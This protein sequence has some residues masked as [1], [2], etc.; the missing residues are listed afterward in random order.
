MAS[1]GVSAVTNENGLYSWWPWK[2]MLDLILWCCLWCLINA[3]LQLGGRPEDSW[4]RRDDPASAG[5]GSGHNN[6]RSR[7]AYNVSQRQQITL[8]P[9]QCLPCSTYNTWIYPD[10]TGNI[11]TILKFK[12]K[13]EFF[14]LPSSCAR[15]F[16]ATFFFFFFCK[17][18]YHLFGDGEGGL[19]L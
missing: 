1:R 5:V 19:R 18:L 3:V 6:R 4:Q 12:S 16:F 7:Y 11:C 14:L 9:R 8:V 17:S 10:F 15:V 13:A 2:F